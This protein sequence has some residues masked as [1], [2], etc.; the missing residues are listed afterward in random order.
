M[1]FDSIN[2]I[3]G[4]GGCK[5]ACWRKQG[6]DQE[7]ISPDHKKKKMPGA[8]LQKVYHTFNFSCISS[9]RSL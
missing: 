8:F 4:T 7:L 3:L 5:A 9:S 6:G 2:G 1:A